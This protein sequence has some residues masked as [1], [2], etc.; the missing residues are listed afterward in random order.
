VSPPGI[1]KISSSDG[2]EQGKGVSKG[3][4]DE[5]RAQSHMQQDNLKALDPST[6]RL[7]ELGFY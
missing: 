6:V 1:E 5:P 7:S 3:P 4:P 2:R